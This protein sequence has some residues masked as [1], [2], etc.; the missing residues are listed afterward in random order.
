MIEIATPR[1]LIRSFSTEDWRDLQ[2]L[3]I[4][5]EAGEF[6]FSDYPYP[7]DERGVKEVLNFFARGDDYLAVYEKA[8]KKVIGYIAINNEG[9]IEYNLG[10]CF[11]SAYQ[12][13]GYATEACTA[14]INYVFNN[15]KAEKFVT[16]TAS[17]NGP[18]CRLLE[19]LGFVKTGEQTI[20]LRKDAAGK[21]V[22][23]TGASYELTREKWKQTSELF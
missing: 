20:S 6:A 10:Y 15:Q 8:R 9:K 12:A 18:S 16:G 3:L 13:K 4:D 22:E 17:A 19:K 7:T 23:F 11:H 1:T 14:A 5:K 2:E 21:P